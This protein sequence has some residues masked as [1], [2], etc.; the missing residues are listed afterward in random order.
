MK[1]AKLIEV[2]DDNFEKEVLRSSKP[3]LLDF[4]A[5][6]CGPCKMAGPILDELAGEYEGK[7]TIGKLDVDKNQEIAGKFGVMSIPT[8]I[9]FE[10]GEEVDKQIGFAGKEGYEAMIKKVAD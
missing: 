3:V 4:Y 6:W 10:K 8:V 5:D 1:M 2:E 7:V 9:M